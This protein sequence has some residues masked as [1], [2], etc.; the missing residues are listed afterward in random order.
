MTVVSESA[1]E[2]FVI[3]VLRN[4]SPHSDS[5]QRNVTRSKSLRHANQVRDNLPVI[6]SKPLTRAAKARHHLVSD[7][8][9]PVLVA[10]FPHALEVSIRRNK[11]SIRSDDCLQN[12]RRN[13]MRAFQLDNFFDHGQRSLRRLPSAFYAVIRIK[14]AHYARNPRLRR[15]SPRIARKA[16]GTRRRAVIR[17]IARHDFVP[18]GK[19][20]SD[21]DGVLVRFRAAICKKERINIARSNLR[22]LRS[23]PRPRLR[24]HERIGIGQHRRLLGNSPDDALIAVSN[25]Y[26]HQLAVEV[27][28][29]LPFRSPEINAPRPRHRNG[30]DLR[31]RRPLKQR[32]FL[33]EIN[34]LLAGHGRGRYSRRHSC[35][36]STFVFTTESQR[37]RENL[38]H[39]SYYS[40]GQQRRV[41]VDQETNAHSRQ[42]HVGKQLCLMDW[43]NSL[44]CFQLQNHFLPHNQ[45]DPITAVEL[46]ALVR[47]WKVDLTLEGQPAQMQFV[48]EALLISGLQQPRTEMPMH[49]NGCSNDRTGSRVSLVFVF[50]VSLCLCGEAAHSNHLNEAQNFRECS[51]AQRST[52]IF[53]SV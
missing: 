19:D 15:P 20:A 28:E 17:P 9:N 3:K 40:L 51:F 13:R 12:E 23:Q 42:L 31:L 14:Y 10:Q 53:F 8:Q 47:N 18:S 2:H 32:V 46:E 39:S 52:T 50:S 49:F 41:E 26:R 5:A 22:Q 30:I 35:L 36:V 25:V 45:V 27:D 1:I 44:N 38:Q 43:H 37:H 33:R 29:A 7:H 11:N 6:D 34:N 48:A 24:S 4:M 16:H 21:L